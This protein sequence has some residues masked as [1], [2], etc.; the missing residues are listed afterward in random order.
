[1]TLLRRFLIPLSLLA[2]GP[3]MAGEPGAPLSGFYVGGHVGYM[4]GQAT[5]ALGD[6]IG[7]DWAGGTTPYGAWFGGVQAGYEHFFDSRLMLGVELDMSFTDSSDLSQWMSYRA[8]STGSA[9]EQLEYLATLRG[10]AGYSMG[11]F[12]PFVTGGIAWASTRFSRTDLTTGNEDANPSNVRLGYSLGAGLDYRLDRRWT[13]RAEY[14]YTNLGLTGWIFNSA[15]ARYDSL[16][17][18]NRFR[19]ALNYK[20]GVEDEK[21]EEGKVESRGPL[22]WEL[23]GQTTFIYQG[24]PP[25]YALYSGQ[26]SLPPEGQ[27]RD[28]WTVSG[29][30]GVRLWQGGQ[31]YFNPETLQ[32]FGVGDTT[33]AAGFPNGEAQK[34]NFP[35][36]RFNVSR[37]YLRQEI[38]LGGE[39]EA[40]EGEYGQLSGERDIDRV[41]LQLGK[42]SVKDVF[43]GNAYAEDPRLDFLNWSIWAS[44]AF[45]YPADRLGF[46]WGLMAE[47]NRKN[48]AVRA[49]YFLV[50]DVSNAN[51]FDM[52]LFVRG[53][54]LG[55]LELRYTPYGRPGSFRL[56]SW[57]NSVFSGSYSE[58]VSLAAQ[59]AGLN[60]NDTLPWTRQGRSKYGFYLNFDQEISD[61]V[62]MFGR[63]SWNDGRTEIMSF[64]DIDSSLS[65]GVSIKGT[66][67]G[68]PDDR[69]GIAGAINNI[70]GDHASFLNAGG[71]GVTIGD[72]ALSYASENVFETYYAFQLRKGIVLTADYQFLGNPAYNLVRGPVNV[73]SGRLHMQ[74]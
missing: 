11:A 60:A 41:T 64:T 56:G 44:G 35:Y 36:P 28:T 30:L 7:L 67:W 4:F 55:E 15:P 43:D 17:D 57:Y 23:H 70:S 61:T 8:T 50:P 3:A 40:V 26:N 66:R 59:I 24:Y 73:F 65:L 37:L 6:P 27:S 16:Y 48:F 51:T 74:F 54:Y 47:L 31:L 38:G 1:M 42:Y 10:R 19:L 49:G 9:N 33:G 58:A 2:G 39:S 18:L 25:I 32:G 20:F 72:G 34:S 52:S 62:G 69:V 14:L 12:T 29:F 13:A 46:S 5:A 45:D 22:T 68:R 21:K 71:L 63:F 53:G